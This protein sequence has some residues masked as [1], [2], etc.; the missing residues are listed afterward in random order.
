MSTT[1]FT[2]FSRKTDTDDTKKPMPTTAPN[3]TTTREIGITPW[4]SVELTNDEYHKHY[5][6]SFPM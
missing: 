2:L 5:Y 6:G 4:H 3:Q 1:R